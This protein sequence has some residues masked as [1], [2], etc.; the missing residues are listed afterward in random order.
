MQRLQAGAP[1]EHM[2]PERRLVARDFGEGTIIS[3][4]D[5][6]E[7]AVLVLTQVQVGPLNPICN[8]KP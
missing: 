8:R 7:Q 1:K 2:P 5:T 6:L 3:R 4:V